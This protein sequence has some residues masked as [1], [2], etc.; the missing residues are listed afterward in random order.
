MFYKFEYRDIVVLFDVL[1]DDIVVFWQTCP[2]RVCD[3]IEYKLFRK[4]GKW[5]WARRAPRS[6]NT[7]EWRVL[8]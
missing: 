3:E 1:G 4:Y 2:Q 8:I 6:L 7:D 5:P